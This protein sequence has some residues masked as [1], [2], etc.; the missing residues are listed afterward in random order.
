MGI[1]LLVGHKAGIGLMNNAAGVGFSSG[2]HQRRTQLLKVGRAGLAAVGPDT[3]TGMVAKLGD[4]LLGLL[5]RP[6]DKIAA[7][8][9][10]QPDGKILVDQKSGGIT[11]IVKFLLFQP[12]RRGEPY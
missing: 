8:G 2:Q 5:H 12:N 10:H 7:V 9:S 3:D 11:L 6:T 4:H 1:I